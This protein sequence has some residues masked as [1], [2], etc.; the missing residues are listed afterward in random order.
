MV[1]AIKA[2]H[3]LSNFKALCTF[4]HLPASSKYFQLIQQKVSAAMFMSKAINAVTYLHLLGLTT[5]IM[6]LKLYP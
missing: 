4:T 6:A 2:E 3:Q 1:F 5:E